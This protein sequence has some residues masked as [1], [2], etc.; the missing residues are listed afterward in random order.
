MGCIMSRCH[1]CN[2]NILDDSMVCPLCNGVLDFS[3]SKRSPESN[4][5]QDNTS[6]EK[7]Q[8]DSEYDENYEP[9]DIDAYNS[10]S[11]MYPDVEPAMKKIKFVIKLLIFI[12][13]IVECVL[14]LINYLTYDGFKWSI[15]CGAAMVY[16]CFTVAYSFQHNTGHRSKMLFQ[17]LGAMALAVIIDFIIGYSGWSLNYAI[18]SAIML[19]DVAILILMMVNS[20]N[21]Q[22]YIILQITMLAISIIFMILVFADIISYPV[23]TIIATA[24]SGIILAGTLVFG[25]KK[26]V[27]ELFR[28]FRV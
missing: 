12:S 16:M 14:M 1:R 27:N 18:P 20:G 19:L 24:F 23:L 21:W 11:V 5:V 13:F 22:S 4:K 15:I 17:A 2:V 6:D 10:C 3:E 26:A 28:R 7:V 25:D 9:D 8:E